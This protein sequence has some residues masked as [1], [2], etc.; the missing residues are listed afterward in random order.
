M[1]RSIPSSFTASRADA[2]EAYALESDVKA[3]WDRVAEVTGQIDALKTR[4]R[5]QREATEDE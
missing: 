1:E 3:L 2:P 5:A 4:R